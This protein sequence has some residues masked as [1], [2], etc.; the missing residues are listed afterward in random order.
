MNEKTRYTIGM[1]ALIM[2]FLSITAAGLAVI[3]VSIK[4]PTPAP[5]GIRIFLSLAGIILIACVIALIK[6]RREWEIKQRQNKKLLEN[7]SFCQ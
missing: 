6:D 7:N 3:Y 2:M 1:I 5:L 4:P